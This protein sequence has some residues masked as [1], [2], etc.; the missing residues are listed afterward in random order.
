MID[1][2]RLDMYKTIY[3]LVAI[4]IFT[5]IYYKKLL[6]IEVN[7][8]KP[9][10]MLKRILYVL[11]LLGFINTFSYT[12]DKTLK[13]MLLVILISGITIYNLHYSL[14]KCNE[15][16][17]QYKLT[18]YVRI[19][20][21]IITMSILLNFVNDNELFSFLYEDFIRNKGSELFTKKSVNQIDLSGRDKLPEYCPDMKKYTSDK[22]EIKKW[23]NLSSQEKNNCLVSHSSGDKGKGQRADIYSNVYN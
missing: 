13:I 17:F 8:S 2:N 10:Q 20:L 4:T 19:I 9:K 22:D 18:L 14:K 23:D 5:I 12:N 21:V 7:E 6:T 1:T 3:F 11:I 16:S 15:I